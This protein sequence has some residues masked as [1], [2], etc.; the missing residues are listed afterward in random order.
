MSLVDV[1]LKVENLMTD[2][3]YF[4]VK[5]KYW[6]KNL[7]VI[8]F[9]SGPPNLWARLYPW[10]HDSQNWPTWASMHLHC[11]TQSAGIM[12]PFVGVRL[13]EPNVKLDRKPTS[14]LE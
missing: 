13:A 1:L 11:S 2:L 5:H 6:K 9:V 10:E 4:L 12:A 14:P 7:H 8:H 3:F